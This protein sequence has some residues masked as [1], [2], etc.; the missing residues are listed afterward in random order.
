MLRL[1]KAQQF[2]AVGCRTSLIG[3]RFAGRYAMLY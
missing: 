3:R 2:A 1:N